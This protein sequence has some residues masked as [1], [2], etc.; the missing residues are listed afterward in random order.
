MN[1]VIRGLGGSLHELSNQREGRLLN[2]NELLRRLLYDLLR[3][4]CGG[5]GLLWDV[6]HLGDDGEEGNKSCGEKENADDN[7]DVSVCILDQ[8]VLDFHI[9]GGC[10]RNFSLLLIEI[11]VMGL[12]EGGT[13]NEFI[14]DLRDLCSGETSGL[15]EEQKTVLGAGEEA[16]IIDVGVLRSLKLEGFTVIFEGDEDGREI[17]GIL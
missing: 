17:G 4:V 14:G 15:S 12:K 9:E 11:G 5:D 1:D 10:H 6:G 8:F 7:E 2:L 13:E 3:E 16:V